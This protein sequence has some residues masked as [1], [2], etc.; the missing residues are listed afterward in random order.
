MCCEFHIGINYPGKR[1]ECRRKCS[2]IIKSD[3]KKIDKKHNKKKGKK[4]EK[5]KK[6]EKSKKGEK[7]KKKKK[8]NN[9]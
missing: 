9:E 6:G 8:G 4:D 2:K 5:G 1:L 7:T 3:K